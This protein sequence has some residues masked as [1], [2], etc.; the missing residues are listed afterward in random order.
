LQEKLE[1]Y[2]AMVKLQKR[3]WKWWEAR[4]LYY[5]VHPISFI[6]SCFTSV[7]WPPLPSVTRSGLIR[8]SRW[9]EELVKSLNE[10]CKRYGLRGRPPTVLEL[11]FWYLLISSLLLH[12]YPSFACFG[13]VTI[14]VIFIFWNL[15]MWL[16]FISD[17]LNKLPTLFVMYRLQLIPVCMCLIHLVFFCQACKIWFKAC[18]NR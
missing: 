10:Q 1:R 15:N 2:N 14:Q 9:V 4:G 5:F 8:Y 6:A 11:P 17:L 18:F 16:L 3:G 12:F 13:C 7:V